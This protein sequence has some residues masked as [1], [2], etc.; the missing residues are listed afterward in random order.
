[1]NDNLR[2]TMAKVKTTYDKLVKRTKSSDKNTTDTS[3]TSEKF[4]NKINLPEGLNKYK[5]QILA[6]TSA[7]TVSVVVISGVMA[8]N[9]LQT[10]ENN[11]FKT[12]CYVVSLNGAEIGKIRKTEDLDETIADIQRDLQSQFKVRME[13]T[14]DFEV[15]ESKAK[16]SEI[17]SEED[18][19]DKVKTLV[20]YEA[21]AYA[22][23]VDNQ[24]IGVLK[25]KEEADKVL[26]TV[27]ANYTSRYN[28]DELIDASF[29]EN[30]KVEEIN[31]K[32]SEISNVEKLTEYIL[33]GTNEKVTYIIQD[34]DTLWDIAA[35]SEMTVEELQAANPD[36]VPEKIRPGDELNLTVA[37]PFINVNVKRY[38]V[39]EEKIKYDTQYEN[40]S[41]MYSDETKVKTS[42]QN[43][44]SQVKSIVTEQNGVEIAREV[45]EENVI[46]EPTTEVV[47]VG[48]QT[49]PPRYG[50][51]TF[52]NPLP[53]STISSRYG[54]RAGGFH[55][56]IDMAKASGSSIKAADG[57]TVI[58]AGWYGSY[59]NLVEIDHGGGFTTRYAH[60]SSINV[61]VG[62]KVYQGQVIAAVGSTGFSTG[63]HLHFE[64]RKYGSTL[65]PS[66]YIG[67][68]Y[69]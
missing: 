19:L 3:A 52:I 24:K 69:K 35:G 15:V 34:G 41:Y 5:K 44:V 67:V 4:F 48:T 6:A 36:M 12:K 60:C 1:M 56:G 30:V 40:V 65:N 62:S 61:S 32:V 8:L 29:A 68:K 43:G 2:N 14:T 9:Y 33:T 45:V 53:A 10:G 47:L 21:T 57:G 39:A 23:V 7:V 46:T 18:L 66:S 37:K 16:D 49:P 63:P 51:G 13:V 64:V 11:I 17:I 58:F 50:T 28:K 20:D 25:T 31:T 55:Y 42:G 38:N 26:E 59:G 54:S 22:I 27:K